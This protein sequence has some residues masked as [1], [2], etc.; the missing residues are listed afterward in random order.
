MSH[1]LRTPLTAI[2]GNVELI[3]RYGMDDN[4]LDAIDSET[5]RM[6]RLVNDLLL[7]A[8]A[9]NGELK[10]NIEELDLD[11]IVDEAYREARILAKDRDLKVTVIDFEP[12]RINGDAD[13]IKQL[14]S[15]PDQQRHQVHAGRRT[16]QH[17][18]A[19]DRAR[20]RDEGE[21]HGHRH[22][23]GALAAHL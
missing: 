4:S 9:D 1:E 2:S 15:Q 11:I 13:R 8:R 20:R 23:G 22:L 14:L 16:D 5:R 7:L 17:Q 21:G 19:Q 10:L 6:S 3:K 18:P 12:V